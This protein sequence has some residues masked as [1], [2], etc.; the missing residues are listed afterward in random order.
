MEKIYMEE[1]KK[2][3]NILFNFSVVLSFVVAII[4]VFSIGLFGIVSTQKNG[5]ISYAAPLTSDT[6]NFVK[7]D[8]PLGKITSYTSY[9][10]A[11]PNTVGPFVVPKY[12]ADTAKT[13]PVFC[14]E[15]QA[16]TENG[17]TYTKGSV[18]DDYGL[19]YLLNH[20]SANS[21]FTV[22]EY[23][24]S[25]LETYITQ[26]SIW[27]Y[28][29]EKEKADKGSVAS[30][31]KNYL[32][33]EDLTA[34]KNAVRIEDIDDSSKNF[35]LS[36]GTIY[37]AYIKPLVESALKATNY[38]SVSVSAASTDISKTD[39]EKYYQSDVITVNGDPSSSMKR[40]DVSVEGIDGV[41][42]INENGETI[43][44][45][46]NLPAGT[47]FRIRV[48]AEKVTET[49]QNAIINVTGHFDSLTGNYYTN[50]TKQKVV[51]VTGTTIDAKGGTEIEFVGVPD[52]G[53]NGIQTIY[54]IGLVVLLC[55]VGIVYANAKP[56]K[57]NQ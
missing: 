50:E 31:S 21:G 27:M 54:F 42:V 3:K 16:A 23:N 33:P 28:L 15:Y 49:A 35:Q 1:S 14:V 22:T 13:I 2:Q 53:M 46:K 48:P 18:I 30:S 52:T 57:N 37:D 44:S 4:G 34:I 5:L 10:E 25:S 45:L 55:G 26:V 36:E 47:K 9:A 32:S 19:L 43:S 56:V 6:F 20:T 39:D 51:T 11:S 7:S 12:F 41:I 29:Y 8:A 40:F 24:N 17:A 38:A